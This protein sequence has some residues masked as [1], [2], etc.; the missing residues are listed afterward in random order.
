MMMLGLVV[1]GLG[2]LMFLIAYVWS[3]KL[4]FQKSKGVGIAVLLSGPL[5]FI[6]LPVNYLI[7]IAANPR[8]GWPPLVG[9]IG[10][11][12]PTFLGL[13]ICM[14]EVTANQVKGG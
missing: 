4:G 8:E 14:L 13:F 9:F 7:L 2:V 1:L 10:A 3:V 12:P 11:I 5:S 6:L